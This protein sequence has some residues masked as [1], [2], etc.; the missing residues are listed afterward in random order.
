MILWLDDAEMYIS[1]LSQ[2]MLNKVYEKFR[3]D[4]DLF[5]YNLT[6]WR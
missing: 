3:N 4:F 1:Q 6:N 2:E 5:G